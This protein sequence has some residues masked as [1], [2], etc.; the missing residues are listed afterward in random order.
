MNMAKSLILVMAKY[1]NHYFCGNLHTEKDVRKYFKDQNAIF[2]KVVERCRDF[3]EPVPF[4]ENFALSTWTVSG[5]GASVARI[6]NG[7]G[8]LEQETEAPGELIMSVYWASFE[9]A[10]QLFH[11]AIERASSMHFISAVTFG[12]ASIEGY[13]KY[14]S[15]IWNKLHPDQQLIDTKAHSVRFEDKIKEWIPLMT[16]GKQLDRRTRVWSDFLALQKIRDHQGIHPKQSGRAVSY[17][18]LVNI[19]NKFRTGIAGFLVDL[20]ILF[21]EKIPSQ[22]IRVSFTPEIVIQKMN[23]NL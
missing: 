6:N 17:H 4:I 7:S 1:G 14:R 11:Q 20:H 12:V 15:E 2:D 21:D 5:E 13:L 16:G 10:S 23:D 22:I 19:M 9:H 8:D 18:Q 3:N